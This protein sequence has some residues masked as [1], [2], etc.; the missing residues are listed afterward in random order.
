MGAREIF[1]ALPTTL[2]MPAP[3]GSRGQRW[4]SEGAEPAFSEAHALLISLMAKHAA[5]EILV[6]NACASR[7]DPDNLVPGGV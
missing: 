2:C 4:R 6:A 1:T 5:R 3:D 7:A